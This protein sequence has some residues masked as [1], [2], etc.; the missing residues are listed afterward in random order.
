MSSEGG[1]KNGGVSDSP[2]RKK[3]GNKDRDKESS[4]MGQIR[5]EFTQGKGD[6][7]YRVKPDGTPE[8]EDIRDDASVTE[9]LR[10]LGIDDQEERKDD[11]EETDSSQIKGSEERNLFDDAGDSDEDPRNPF[12][13]VAPEDVGRRKRKVTDTGN[14]EFR[15]KLLGDKR[16]MRQAGMHGVSDSE[17]WPDEEKHVR[18][19]PMWMMWHYAR[20]E[21]DSEVERSE[22]EEKSAKVW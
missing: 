9:T 14:E 11:E 21:L 2:R 20:S 7:K 15:E 3:A 1:R 16:Y 10:E 12:Q 13:H 22:K 8:L 5:G 19:M 17:D 6:Y 18:S 4:A